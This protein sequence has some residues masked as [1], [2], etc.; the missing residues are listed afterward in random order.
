MILYNVT[1][2]ID[3]D[4][5]NEWLDWVKDNYIQRTLNTG[6]FYDYKLLRLL[7]VNDDDG[8]TYAVQFFAKSLSLAENFLNNHAQ[9]ITNEHR[10]KFQNR[11]VAFMTLLE[12]VD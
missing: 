12:S 5:E 3:N 4:I 10:L 1:I 2:K 9:E 11:H 7:N 8:I 6:L